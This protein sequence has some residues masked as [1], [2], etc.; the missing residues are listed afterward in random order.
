M[1]QLNKLYNKWLNEKNKGH[2]KDG[3]N[4]EKDAISLFGNQDAILGELDKLFEFYYIQLKG[5]VLD[6]GCSMGGLMY[7]LYNSNKFDFVA[8]VDIDSTAVEMAK[9]YKKINNITDE[10]VFVDTCSIYEL[11]FEDKKFDFIIMKDVGEHLENKENLEL[12]MIE[13][14]RILKDDG[15][16]FIETPNYVFP[17]EVHLKIPMLPFI[18]T[19]SSV[20]FLA[21]LFGKDPDFVNH[22]NFTTPKMFET[23]FKN[24]NFNFNNA[25]EEYK[26]PYIIKNSEKLSGRFKFIGGLFRVLN[27]IG[28][29][30]FIVWLFKFTKMYPSL[31]Y[32]VSKK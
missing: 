32:I 29:S 19:K 3:S 25:Y 10:K 31:W 9:E 4:V 20:K 22:L 18:S 17:M 26:L 16:I 30:N 11:P 28:L 7:S 13:L 2:Y 23:I 8:G 27:K 15:H 24:T 12:A 1:E 21:K 6:V 5:N 14:K